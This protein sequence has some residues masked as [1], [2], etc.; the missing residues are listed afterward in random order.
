MFALDPPESE[1]ASEEQDMVISLDAESYTVGGRQTGEPPKL[2]VASDG[3]AQAWRHGVRASF[4]LPKQQ[5]E[6]L[7]RELTDD[8]DGLDPSIL[9]ATDQGWIR[10]AVVAPDDGRKV[11]V[12]VYGRNGPDGFDRAVGRLMELIES[13]HAEGVTD[14]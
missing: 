13:I 9:A 14:D 12:T 6:R 2:R 7:R 11:E 4:T 3:T 10:V 1:R 8:L 5:L